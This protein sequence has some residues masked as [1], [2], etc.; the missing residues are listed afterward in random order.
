MKVNADLSHWVVVG[1]RCYDETYDDDWS[2]I[3]ELVAGRCHLIHARVG[4]SEGPQ[5]PDPSAK[6]YASDLEYHEK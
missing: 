6:E 2:E 4:Y 5:V 3:L 1:E